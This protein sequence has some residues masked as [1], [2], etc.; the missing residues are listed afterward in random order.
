[1]LVNV[2]DQ[3]SVKKVLRIEV[4]EEDVKQEVDDAYKKLR[5]EVKVKGFRPGKTPRSVLEGLYRK[6][7][8]ADVLSRLIQTSFSDA[9]EKSGLEV[10]GQPQIDFPDF[11]GKGPIKYDVTVEVTPEIGDIDLS[12]MTF[13]KSIYQVGEEELDLQ[14]NL[15]QKR[16]AEYK[17]IE[18][19]RPVQ[20]NDW[21]TIDYE[22]FVD[23]K[24]YEE[25]EQTENFLMKIGD[26]TIHADLDEGLTGLEAGDSKEITVNFAD[27]HPNRK[28]AG[29]SITFKVTL[30]EI[31]QEILPELDQDFC[32]KF[33]DFDSL[34]ALK[35][36]IRQNLES[37]Y[38]NRANQEINEQVFQALLE[39]TEFEV[40][41]QMIDYEL[42]NILMDAQ[43]TM[44]QYNIT[45]E[46]A[47]F[48]KESISERYRDLA[49]KQAK[50]HLILS[51]IIKQEK[52]ELSDTEYKAGLQGMAMT[53]AQNPEE[54]D[55]FFKENE[56]QA[57]QFKNSL[58]EK[59]AINLIIENSTI[60]E[61]Q[62]QTSSNSAQDS[63]DDD[64]TNDA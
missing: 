61:E 48:T 44:M 60:E 19:N 47:G 20:S 6:N 10:V 50:R 42:N 5:K 26:G 36:G 41:D 63:P 35:S 34:D 31:K 21:V 27:T 56:P 64:V 51:K 16:I 22:G 3:S 1:M 45:P 9:I 39:K 59:K 15:L 2:E 11:E 32:K 62:V 46:Q 57:T 49:I 43:N 54:I 37:E 14:V 58:L 13:K 18:E 12:G 28:L 53:L 40:P 38:A 23:G 33:G 17:T 24:P 8:N 55:R 4:P 29:K 30:K 25:T 7:V 52:L